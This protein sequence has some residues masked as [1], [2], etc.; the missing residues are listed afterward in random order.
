MNQFSVSV[1]ITIIC[2]FLA[3]VVDT[4]CLRLCVMCSNCYVNTVCDCPFSQMT[5]YKILFI[6]WWPRIGLSWCSRCV[7][8]S[9]HSGLLWA[10][11]EFII[12]F[13][14]SYSLIYI[15]KWNNLKFCTRNAK[16]ATE[17]VYDNSH[18]RK[19]RKMST[20]KHFNSRANQRT[21]SSTKR[22]KQNQNPIHT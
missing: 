5:D 13:F 2:S 20:H 12:N 4:L 22:K 6:Q 18:V 16:E 17:I 8:M 10:N 21:D 15:L 19:T 7:F 9:I 1:S 3:F 14:Y 11:F